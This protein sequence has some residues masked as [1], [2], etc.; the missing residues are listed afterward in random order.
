M[1]QKERYIKIEADINDIEDAMVNGSLEVGSLIIRNG[2]VWE[3]MVAQDLEDV[4]DTAE[5]INDIAVVVKHSGHAASIPLGQDR[6]P[7]LTRFG[8]QPT[9]IIRFT[10]DFNMKGP[11][12][13]RDA[14]ATLAVGTYLTI[15]NNEFRTLNAGGTRRAWAVV[16]KGRSGA[17]EEYEITTAGMPHDVVVA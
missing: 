7:N 3:E 6:Q 10:K 13:T 5:N 8:W 15:N 4:T 16:T 11:I 17:N 12:S 14:D 2:D 9:A 1:E